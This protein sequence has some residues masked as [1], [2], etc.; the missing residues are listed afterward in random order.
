MDMSML[1]NLFYTY[2][3][4]G[5]TSQM[6]HILYIRILQHNNNIFNVCLFQSK[7]TNSAMNCS[8]NVLVSL[9]LSLVTNVTFL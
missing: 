9:V 2:M 7:D 4:H 8:M 3:H 5:G 1:L 6:Y